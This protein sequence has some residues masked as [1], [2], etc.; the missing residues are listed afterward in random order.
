MSAGPV[1]EVLAAGPGFAKCMLGNVA[2]V[3]GALEA[4]VQFFSCY[5]GTPSSEVGDTFAVIAEGAGVRFEYSVNEKITVETAFGACLTG[6]RT[7]CSM[8][9]LGLNFAGDPICTMPYIGVEGGMVIVSA[10]DPS[11]IT[12]P[13]EQDQRHFSDFLF[14]P[15]FDP[16]TPED[17]RRMTKF[18]FELSE[19]TRLPVIMR[20]TTRVC[21]TSGMVEF[22][23]LPADR[24][25]IVFEKNP[26]RYVP[27]PINARRM[28]KELTDRYA[29]AEELLAK[30]EFFPIS[31][32][33]RKGVI[34]SGV[35]A[36]Y[37]MHAITELEASGDVRILKVGAYP[38]PKTVLDHF[39]AEV[40]SVLVVEELTP[41]VEDKVTLAAYR[42]GRQIP[43]YGKRTGH[44]PFEFEYGPDMVEAAL[45]RYL[46]LPEKKTAETP[47]VGIPPRPPVLCPGC[48]HRTTFH[49]AKKVFGKDTVYFNDIGC[50]TL[51]YGPPLESC[52]ALLC[53]GASITLASGHSRMTG[54][55]SVAYIGDSTFFHSGMTALANAYRNDDPVTVVIL[56]NYVTAM[57]GFQPSVAA[58]PGEGGNAGRDGRDFSIEDAVRGLGVEEVYSIDPFDEELAAEAFKKAKEGAGLNVVVA[59]SPCVNYDRRLGLMPK[60]APFEIDLEKCGG[61]SLCIRMLGCPAAYIED[62]KYYINAGL[63]NGCSLCAEVCPSGAIRQCGGDEK[64]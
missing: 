37:S 16:A 39:L 41:Y 53:M 47:A 52:D 27:I 9:H 3:R 15:V 46:E 18:A 34:S 58:R 38:L 44:F 59:N 6:A 5:P 14:Y 60:R 64:D 24:N 23:E 50:Y 26:P 7:M 19:L 45:R 62:E 30:S 42:S 25:E 13:N 17:A 32:K 43:I 1:H 35:A 10:G 55:R 49:R 57:T 63:C 2:I 54:K 28:R 20:P 8:K 4:G 31:G 36:A 56:N 11:A 48:P 21:H 29:L 51:G 61:C 22:D 40:D 33:G 12:S